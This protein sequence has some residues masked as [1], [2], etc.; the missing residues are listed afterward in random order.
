MLVTVSLLVTGSPR[1]IPTVPEE[2]SREP[3]RDQPYFSSTSFQR[4]NI[5]FLCV[6][7]SLLLFFR[8]FESWLVFFP[9]SQSFCLLQPLL[10][11]YTYPIFDAIREPTTAVTA[12]S[13]Q[14]SI[15]NHS[16]YVGL[17]VEITRFPA[18][19]RIIGAG[20]V[21]SP[22][23]TPFSISRVNGL[24]GSQ[25]RPSRIVPKALEL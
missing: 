10:W 1:G 6:P 12:V 23:P 8:Q 13:T 4:L 14:F 16:G 22:L 15:D 5:H 25:T 11:L 18:W 21:P 17:R 3:G 20:S 7:L 2:P 9:C 24:G 19:S